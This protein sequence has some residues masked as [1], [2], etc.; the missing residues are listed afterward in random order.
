MNIF[1]LKKF[2]YWLDSKNNNIIKEEN[3]FNLLYDVWV[4]S[5]LWHV[6]NNNCIRNKLPKILCK[7]WYSYIL[8]IRDGY[9]V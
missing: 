8:N 4:Y 1:L 7:F 9:M 3:E 6:I 5:R 2:E